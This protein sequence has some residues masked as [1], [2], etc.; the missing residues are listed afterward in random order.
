MGAQNAENG[1]DNLIRRL[2]PEA[3]A[4]THTPAGHSRIGRPGPLHT[5]S[6]SSSS[7]TSALAPCRAAWCTGLMGCAVQHGEPGRCGPHSYPPQWHNLWP[8]S[9]RCWVKRAW[10]WRR[11]LQA[12]H[13]YMGVHPRVS[14]ARDSFFKRPSGPESIAQ[15]TIG[16]TKIRSPIYQGLRDSFVRVENIVRS[17]TCLLVRSSPP[18]VSR[19]IRLFVVNSVDAVKRTRSGAHISK[20][21]GKIFPL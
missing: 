3:R 1:A 8:E 15:P 12:G 5:H 16:E 13:L 9:R 17:V 10:L 18:A 20:K 11:V 14:R 21:H 19:S 6:I 7:S 4:T 2:V